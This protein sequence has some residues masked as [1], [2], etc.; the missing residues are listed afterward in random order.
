M[1]IKTHSIKFSKVKSHKVKRG[2]IVLDLSKN[3]ISTRLEEEKIDIEMQD[4]MR[5]KR[6]AEI[7][8]E[9]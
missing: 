3:N 8:L 6:F 9:D 5:K 2:K 1:N 7:M 4:L